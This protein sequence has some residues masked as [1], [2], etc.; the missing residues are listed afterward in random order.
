MIDRD[1]VCF[2]VSV[3]GG[4]YELENERTT[5]SDHAINQKNRLKGTGLTA[6]N[7]DLAI[8]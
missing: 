6:I 4:I 5:N 8:F 7:E 2:H 1:G 3:I